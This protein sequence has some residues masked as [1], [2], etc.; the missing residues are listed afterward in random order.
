M[1]ATLLP[2]NGVLALSGYG[3]RVWIER[4]I[5]AQRMV[6]GASVAKSG[7]PELL[8]GSSAWSCLDIQELSASTRSGG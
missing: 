3:V 7:F 1:N 6:W 4:G 8:R 5:C 2:K